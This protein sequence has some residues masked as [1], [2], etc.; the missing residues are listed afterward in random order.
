MAKGIEATQTVAREGKIVAMTLGLGE[1]GVSDGVDETH[2]RIDDISAISQ[3]QLQFKL[4]LFLIC[5][6]KHS[7]LCLHD[8]YCVDTRGRKKICQ[9]GLWLKSLP[10]YQKP[11]GPPKGSAV[12]K[13]YIYTREFEHA[14]VWLDIENSQGKVTWK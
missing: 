4:A 6:E 11:L 10:E 8:G 9:S 1:S 7:Y 13:G 12:K 3:D 2:K 5:A 14:S